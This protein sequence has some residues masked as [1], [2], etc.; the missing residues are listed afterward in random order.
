VDSQK[1]IRRAM[2]IARGAHMADGGTPTNHQ[3]SEQENPTRNLNNIGLYS[4]AAEAARALPQQKGTPQQMLASL[5][6]VKPEEIRWSGVK[7]ALSGQKTIN[8]NDLA[9]YFQQSLPQIEYGTSNKYSQYT[10]PGGKNYVEHV[11]SIPSDLN[12]S[13]PSSIGEPNAFTSSH[14]RGVENPL[15]HVRMSDRETPDPKPAPLRLP[16]SR[17]IKVASSDA[18]EKTETNGWDTG[19]PGLVINRPLSKKSGNNFVLTHEPSG[20]AIKSFDQNGDH[21]K[22]HHAMELANRIGS[23][24]NWDNLKTKEDVHNLFPKGSDERENIV[25]ELSARASPIPVSK[26]A[27]ESF[28]PERILHLEEVQSD[29]AQ[30]GRKEGFKKELPDIPKSAPKPKFAVIKHPNYRFDIS[31][32]KHHKYILEE[33]YDDGS[34]MTFDLGYSKD[35]E[36]ALKTAKTLQPES[37]LYDPDPTGEIAKWNE[38]N[39]KNKYHRVAEAPYVTSTDKWTDLALKHALTQA[40]KGGYDRL[41]WTPGEQHADRYSLREYINKLAHVPDPNMPGHGTLYGFDKR[42]NLN[43]QKRLKDEE[44]PDYIGKEVAQKLLSSP[45]I[46]GDHRLDYRDAPA[47]YFE[48]ILENQDLGVGGEGMIGYY[49]SILPKRLLALAREHDQNAQIAPHKTTDKK[50]KGFPSIKITPEMRESILKNGF[51]AYR[52]GGY[53]EKPTTY[54][55]HSV[56]SATNKIA[57]PRQ[58]IHRAMML[59]KGIE[60]A[61]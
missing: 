1:A 30:Q 35:P 48:R 17:K 13:S 26:K 47:V 12:Y 54:N 59:A 57:D 15:L 27:Q 40:A 8:K 52:K 23:V 6:G 19:I 4:A 28:N 24:T 2:M 55:T 3:P 7:D 5:K 36:E 20:Y 31:S 42:K 33:F 34:S 18:N 11:L 53:V 25:K 43:F 32:Y 46:Q 9:D 61:I 49:N 21:L 51:K 44:L 60:N 22:F 38:E 10:I 50:I 16:K 58:V 37:Q 29:W 41:I 45:L 14:W 39:R 56:D